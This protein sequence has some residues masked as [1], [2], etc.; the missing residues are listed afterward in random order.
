[1]DGIVDVCIDGSFRDIDV[2]QCETQPYEQRHIDR[3]EIDGAVEQ[4]DRG[5]PLMGELK[6]SS[7]SQTLALFLSVFQ[8]FH[9]AVETHGKFSGDTVDAQTVTPVRGQLDFDHIIVEGRKILQRFADLKAAYR[10]IQHQY[11][12]SEFRQS[13]FGAGAD[14]TVTLHTPKF[15]M[16]DLHAVGHDGAY[17]SHRYILARGD[18]LRS[19]Y[20]LP[21]GGTQIDLADT[22]LV[23]IG[24]FFTG[25]HISDDDLLRHP[26]LFQGVNFQAD[27][28]ELSANLFGRNPFQVDPLF[29]P[30]TCHYH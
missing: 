9:R 20:D 24:M 7:D 25:L 22:Q 23:G 17:G 26:I 11:P 19:A 16:L 28:V 1:M 5:I 8:R 2:D 18:I 13:E 3:L 21:H 14:H 6:N 12:I 4:V 29:Q 15:G 27:T 10:L 30:C